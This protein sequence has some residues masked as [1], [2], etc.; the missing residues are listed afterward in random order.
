[1]DF[2]ENNHDLS[3][4]PEVRFS[5]K[6]KSLGLTVS[7]AESCTGGTIATLLSKHPGSS[8]FYKGSV[9][10]YCNEVKH[11]VLHVDQKV[12]DEKGAVSCETVEQMA[13]NVRTLMDTDLGISV[14]GVAGPDGGTPETPVGTVWIAVAGASGVQAKC[15]HLT[16]SREKN[17]A[18][19]AREAIFLAEEFVNNLE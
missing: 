11:N 16:L 6:L 18:L 17:I 10:S 15:L 9:V 3:V 7:T 8:S 5:A 19:A 14:S 4:L 1:M 2:M 13:A 12:L